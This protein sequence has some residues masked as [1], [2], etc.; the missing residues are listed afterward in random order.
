MNLISMIDNNELYMFN[1]Y[2]QTYNEF[3]IYDLYT[4]YII[5]H[6]IVLAIDAIYDL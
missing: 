1:Y 3:I 5:N 6:K 4:L 2:V